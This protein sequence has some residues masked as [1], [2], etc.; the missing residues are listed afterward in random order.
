[1]GKGSDVPEGAVKLVAGVSDPGND[2]F[3]RVRRWWFGCSDQ[4]RFRHQM[5]FARGLATANSQHA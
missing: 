4:A 1:M 5:N 2:R 3:S